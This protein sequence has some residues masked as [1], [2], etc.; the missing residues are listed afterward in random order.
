LTKTREQ[1]LKKEYRRDYFYRIHN[2]ELE[3]QLKKDK[4]V[5]DTYVEPVIQ[6]QLRERTQLQKI[7]CN[8]SKD[9][10]PH[11]IVMRRIRAIDAMVALSRRQEVPCR[12]PRLSKLSSGSPQEGSPMPK[13]ESPIPDAFPL[14]CEK[15]QCIFCIGDERKSYDQRMRTFSKP[16]KMMDHV[17]SHLNKESAGIVACCHPVCKAEGLVLNNILHFKNHVQLVHGI[18]LREPKYKS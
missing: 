1:E 13:E 5:A 11:D 2:E 9:L 15:T 6:H 8:L 17:E 4:V 10:S 3:R 12:E 16:D 7:M 18:R 14:V